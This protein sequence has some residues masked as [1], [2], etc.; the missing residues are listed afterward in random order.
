[1]PEQEQTSHSPVGPI[2]VA[3]GAI[4]L[5]GTLY[6]GGVGVGPLPPLGPFLDPVAG[7]WSVARSATLPQELS[8]SIPGLTGEV[9]VVYDRR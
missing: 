3:A 9:E 1:M 5:A 6:V 8:G 4:A 2:R 7:V